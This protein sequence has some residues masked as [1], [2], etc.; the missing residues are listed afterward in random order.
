MP[1]YSIISLMIGLFGASYTVITAF[2]NALDKKIELVISEAAESINQLKEYR[3]E[4]TLNQGLHIQRNISLGKK[5]WT[6][7]HLT[8]IALFWVYAYGIAYWAVTHWD[9]LGDKNVPGCWCG[10][11]ISAFVIN[12][13]C[14]G[15][16]VGAWF[17]IRHQNVAMK[18]FCKCAGEKQ[19]AQQIKPV[20]IP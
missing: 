2:K 7:S 15:M 20:T 8:I 14:A 4:A 13:W 1:L 12:I 9:S 11:L 5:V 18:V 6:G 10:I 16:A 19:A 3:L 17:L